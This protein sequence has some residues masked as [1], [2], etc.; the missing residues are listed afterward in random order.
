MRKIIVLICCFLS[1]AVCADLAPPQAVG[2]K[3]RFANNP[4]AFDRHDAWCE[5]HGVDEPCEIPGNAFEGGGRGRCERNIHLREYQIDLL[6]ITR[7]QPRIARA[8]PEGPWQT[9]AFLCDLATKN[10]MTAKELR[11][12][13]WVCSEPPVVVDRFCKG[14]EAG[15]RC[16]A[17]VLLDGSSVRFDGVCKRHPESK[18]SYMYGRRTLTRPVLSCEPERPAPPQ[19]LTPVVVWRKLFQ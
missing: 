8:I 5:G 19:T 17:E 18:D 4:G 13:D 6:C 15:Q 14:S 16:T 9:D 2:L 7:P 10:A 12:S 11:E 1:S 3:E